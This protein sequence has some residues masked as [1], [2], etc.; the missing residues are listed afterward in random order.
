MGKREET[1]RGINHGWSCQGSGSFPRAQQRAPALPMSC[2]AGEDAAFLGG[3]WGGRRS[4]GH[5]S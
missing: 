2:V 5:Y 3:K 4:L 1:G